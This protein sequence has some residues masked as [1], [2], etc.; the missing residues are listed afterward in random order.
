MNPL[1]NG[2]MGQLYQIAQ[3]VQ[4][5]KQNPSQLG[6]LLFDH[7]KINEEQ[8]QDI[9]RLGDPS[10]IGNYL[11]NNNILGKSEAEGLYKNI[12]NSK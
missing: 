4:R 8:L 5:I 2:P 9:N 7:G 6:Q 12:T 11:I 10:Q 1:F 3:T